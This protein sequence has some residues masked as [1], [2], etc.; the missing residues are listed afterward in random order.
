MWEGCNIYVDLYNTYCLQE[1]EFYIEQFNTY[2]MKKILLLLCLF[3]SMLSMQGCFWGGRGHGG[4]HHDE[5][6]H[7][8]GH[9]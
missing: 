9:H 1:A 2:K 8:N 3:V 4:Y 7:D 6:R 5:G